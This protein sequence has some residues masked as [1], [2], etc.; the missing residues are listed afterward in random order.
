[1]HNKYFLSVDADDDDDDHDNNNDNN[2]NH[3]EEGGPQRKPQRRQKIIFVLDL[4]LF[5]TGATIQT[6]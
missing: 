6:L 5:D 4:L 2:Y 1:M 3:L